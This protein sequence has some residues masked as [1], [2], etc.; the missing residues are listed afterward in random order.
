MFVQNAPNPYFPPEGRVHWFDGDGMVHGMH[1]SNGKATY[2]NRWIRTS[3]LMRDIASKRSTWK[4]ILEPIDVDHPA[5]PDKNTANTDLVWHNGK[6]LALWWLGGAP[7]RLT[8]PE[9]ETVG[10]EDFGGTL[11]GGVAAHPKV[12][13]TTGE[14]M[15][16]DYNV[17]QPPY[18]KVG[19]VSPDGRV[20]TWQDAALGA[21][22]L[23]HDLAI[24]PNHTILLDFPMTWDKA[25]LAQKRRMVRFDRDHP[26]RYGIMPRAG[27]EIRWFEGPPCYC[28]HTVNAWEETDER[29]H[30]TVVMVACRIDDPIP[31]TPHA[32]EP[33]IPRL[34]FLRLHPFAHMWRFD[35]TDGTVS[36]K[37]LDDI[38][39]EFP[40]MDDR[41]LGHK[42]RYAFHPR[43][44]REQTLMFDALIRYDL[45]NGSSTTATMGEGMVCGEAV[46]APRGPQE[47]DG[48]L[49]TFVQDRRNASSALWVLDAPTMEV[50]AKV[51]MPRRVPF[52]FH[53]HWVPTG[54]A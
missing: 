15:F 3:G 37:P 17:Y 11:A 41:F 22:S 12:C 16:F 29:G 39:T 40:R 53:A 44:A 48:W 50:A 30:E 7:Y 54:G 28:Y 42:T 36:E 35:L 43:V 26:S 4:G 2:R 45:D 27:G 47:G 5:G 38:P 51:V 20:T 46:F 14:M 9:L 10:A 24:T 49:C 33:H 25:L 6:L 31:S 18:L 23:Q 19:V 21:P 32:T 13:P 34:T 8:V 1:L 52:G